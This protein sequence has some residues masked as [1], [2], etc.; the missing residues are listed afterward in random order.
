MTK[1]GGALLRNA[2]AEL[3]RLERFEADVKARGHKLST[4]HVVN[5]MP[6]ARARAREARKLREEGRL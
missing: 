5:V 2:E 4:D 1:P 3:E 6:E